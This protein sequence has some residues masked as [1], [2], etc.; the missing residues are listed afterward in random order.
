METLWSQ[1]PFQEQ[2][3]QSWW[4]PQVAFLILLGDEVILRLGQ[5]KYPQMSVSLA[6]RRRWKDVMRPYVPLQHV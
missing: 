4:K 3:P 1:G 2:P 6:F 5:G